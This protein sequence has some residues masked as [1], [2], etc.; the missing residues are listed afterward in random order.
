MCDVEA[1]FWVGDGVFS[2]EVF[3]GRGVEVLFFWGRYSFSSM[4]RFRRGK[5]HLELKRG[6]VPLG[7][8]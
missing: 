6:N 1:F 4:V 5:R 8:V 2:G 7:K 3:F